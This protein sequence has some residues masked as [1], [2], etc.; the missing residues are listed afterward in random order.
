MT[1]LL[2]MFYVSGV[3]LFAIVNLLSL[4]QLLLVNSNTKS[5]ALSQ[6]SNI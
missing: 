2:E 5:S 1:V 6:Q 4:P 3:S